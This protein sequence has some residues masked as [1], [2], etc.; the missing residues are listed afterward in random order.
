MFLH[1]QNVFLLGQKIEFYMV[2][3]GFYMVKTWLG[4]EGGKMLSQ[5]EKLYFYSVNLY[6]YMIK[7][8]IVWGNYDFLHDQNEF[9]LG[10]KYQFY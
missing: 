4:A 1:G 9:L 3:P 10:Q 8:E 7:K 5:I 6:F 2:K